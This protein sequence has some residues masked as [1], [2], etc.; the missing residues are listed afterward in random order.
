M[1]FLDKEPCSKAG[2]ANFWTR[3]L[4][5][6]K[7]VNLCRTHEQIKLIA[8]E[9]YSSR[10]CGAL[11]QGK[12]VQLYTRAIKTCQGKLLE[13]NL[14]IV[15]TSKESYQGTCQG[16][17]DRLHVRGL[18]CT[19]LKSSWN[20]LKLTW[21]IWNWFGNFWNSGPELSEIQLEISEID[22]KKV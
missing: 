2:H 5:K 6:E 11:S 1:F 16:K 9:N 19:I 10:L 20:Y 8:K 18:I 13:K 15:H 4:V 12:L 3:F 17:L 21:I 22:Q 7:L 14:F